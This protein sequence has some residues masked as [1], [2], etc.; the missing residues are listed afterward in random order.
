MKNHISQPDVKIWFSGTRLRRLDPELAVIEVPNKFVADWLGERYLPQIQDSFKKHF[1]VQPQIRFT[2]SQA[3]NHDLDPFVPRDESRIPAH[4]RPDRLLTFADFVRGRNN[5]FAY[6][7]ARAAAEKPAD[8]YN[9][10][11]FYANLS[12]GKTHLLHAIGNHILY[13]QPEAKVSYLTANQFSSRVAKARR[14]QRVAQFRKDYNE[15]D[16]FL[17]DDIHV[18][19][20]RPSAQ[21][22]L[23]SL[24]NHFYQSGKQMVLAAK[25]HPNQI[26]NL[27]GQLR[28]RLQWGLLT[29]IKAPDQETKM[30]LLKEKAKNHNLR[31][32]D[33]VLFFVANSSNDIKTLNNYLV[34]L[35]T[36]ISLYQREVDM[37]IVKSII[38]DRNHLNLT[39]NNIQKLTAGH[40]NIPLSALVSAKKTRRFSYPRQVAMYLCRELLSLSYK[41]IGRQFCNKDHSTVIYSVKRIAKEKTLN[42][43]VLDDIHK[44]HKL[45]F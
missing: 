44:L 36:Y 30:A 41:E 21:D 5:E 31:I 25:Q 12:V 14:N 13:S 16:V 8:L 33:D 38:H 18:F 27:S 35:Q 7:S 19:T 11:Y 42:R 3:E 24:F 28:S 15:L 1:H 10:L 43:K 9:P 29:E 34:S 22:E 37:S 20:S 2:F 4:E 40:F 39:V 45:L 17:L 6:F 26:E 23:V 32:P